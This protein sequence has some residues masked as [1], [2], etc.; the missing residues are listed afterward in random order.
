MSLQKLVSWY[1]EHDTSSFSSSSSSDSDQNLKPKITKKTKQKEFDPFSSSSSSEDENT[2]KQQKK[3]KSNET[4]PL[5][6]TKQEQKHDQNQKTKNT[7]KTKKKQRIGIAG[8][9]YSDSK[10]STKNVRNQIRVTKQTNKKTKQFAS[11]F[12]KQETQKQTK[13][14][15]K[16]IT[17]T[18]KINSGSR[19]ELLQQ[20]R[21]QEEEEKLKRMKIERVSSIEP[22][23]S[24]I[25][26]RNFERESSNEG[27]S[28]VNEKKNNQNYS[29]RRI[30][31]GW[32]RTQKTTKKSKETKTTRPKNDNTQNRLSQK[33]LED[34][35]KIFA[36]SKKRNKKGEWDNEDEDEDDDVWLD[37]KQKFDQY[38]RNKDSN[39]IAHQQKKDFF[40][41][42]QKKIPTKKAY[43]KRN[44]GNTQPEKKLNKSQQ[45]QIQLLKKKQKNISSWS[46][47]DDDDDEYNYQQTKPNE[48]I[49]GN[50]N[51]QIED[52]NDFVEPEGDPIYYLITKDQTRLSEK[53]NSVLPLKKGEKVQFL[54]LTEKDIFFKGRDENK[55]IGLVHQNYC[56]KL[57][58]GENVS[59]AKKERKEDPKNLK[60]GTETHTSTDVETKEKIIYIVKT[61]YVPDEGS[62]HVLALEKGDQIEYLGETATEGWMNGKDQ[63]GKIG[64]FYISYV[65]LQGQE[66]SSETSTESKS[67]SESGSMSKSNSESGS[68]SGSSS[69]SDTKSESEGVSQSSS[70]ASSPMKIDAK[71]EDKEKKTIY[72]ITSDYT[73]PSTLKTVLK[74]QKGEEIEFIG[75]SKK[76]GWIRGKNKEGKIGFVNQ[77]IL[78]KKLNL[79][80]ESKTKIK[81]KTKPKQNSQQE[82]KQEQK[83]NPRTKKPQKSIF[84]VTKMFMN[85]Q[86]IVNALILMKGDRIEFL[87]IHGNEGWMNG[88]DKSGNIGY[89]HKNYVKLDSGIDPFKTKNP[90]KIAPIISPQEKKIHKNGINGIELDPKKK[91]VK[92]IK[93]QK[94]PEKRKNVLVFKKGTIVE[95]IDKT[96]E[97]WWKG[98][99]SHKIGYFLSENVEELKSQQEMEKKKPKEKEKE[100]TREKT[101]TRTMKKKEKEKDTKSKVY[102]KAIKQF[103]DNPGFGTPL[104]FEKGDVIELIEKLPTGWWKGKLND[105]IGLFPSKCVTK[106][107]TE[108]N[109]N[110]QSTEGKNQTGIKSRKKKIDLSSLTSGNSGIENEKKTTSTTSNF[111]SNNDDKKKVDKIPPKPKPRTKSIQKSQQE[112]E[113]EQEQEQKQKQEQKQE[114]KPKIKPRTKQRTKRVLSN[115]ADDNTK[116]QGVWFYAIKSFENIQGLKNINSYS[117]GDQVKLIEPSKGEWFKG[118]NKKGEIGYYSINN[119][120]VV[121]EDQKVKKT[122]SLVSHGN[123]SIIVE[124]DFNI[125]DF[126]SQPKKKKKKSFFTKRKKKESK[127]KIKKREKEQERER[128]KEQERE[129]ERERE[130]EK[131]RERAKEKEEKKKIYV[132]KTKFN[133][134]NNVNNAV[135]FKKGEKVEFIQSLSNKKGWFVGKDSKNK[136]GFFKLEY[137]EEE[138]QLSTNL[139]ESKPKPKPKTQPQIKEKP[140]TTIKGKNGNKT[141]YYIS[142]CSFS[143]PKNIKKLLAYKKGEK[144]KLIKLTTGDWFSGEN[145]KGKKGYLLK[146]NFIE[147]NEN[148]QE[149]ETEIKKETEKEKEKEKETKP[150]K[151]K[152]KPRTK[153]RTNPKPK[154]KPR[155]KPR[156]IKL[157]AK[158]TTTTRTTKEKEKITK[159]KVYVKAIKK[160][161][162]NPGFGTPLHFKKGDVIELIDELPTGWWKGKLNNKS[163]LFPSKCVTKKVSINE[164]KKSMSKEKSS[165]KSS[166]SPSTVKTTTQHLIAIKALKDTKGLKNALTFRK[167]D[168]FELIKKMGDRWYLVRKS[169]KKGYVP[170]SYMK[171]KKD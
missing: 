13:K 64:Y 11:K 168:T 170:V 171:V 101:K 162:D 75:E 90:K 44:I 111:K 150:P 84:I 21:K 156:T 87:N 109:S 80:S 46:D 5:K 39:P 154:T 126:K 34:Q 28:Q 30:S 93:N 119:F 118:Q 94:N 161:K 83:Q 159:T 121:G 139:I 7:Q 66:D 112:Q 6:N 99:Y 36:K 33:Q 85:N 65:K 53:I 104:H 27:K 157:T 73:P 167:G 14:P 108:I 115:T 144:I 50:G 131:E 155:T 69:S 169:G 147:G 41:S 15:L 71:K 138:S 25:E 79:K 105:E 55:N 120:R 133:N 76:Q 132:A 107:D 70:L 24:R 77:K 22:V 20:K 12:E 97:R 35:K 151:P 68:G 123:G 110:N 106:M 18:S 152:T 56:R 78:K 102:V 153:P 43:P 137:F 19:W 128:E 91:Y 45:Q 51:K 129:R 100:K 29:Q 42:Q 95:L 67:S 3:K 47:E 57:K 26:R 86:G 117:K 88:K 160:F 163:G 142:K 103:K 116:T 166:K 140:S 145:K 98:N 23:G 31:S 135:K 96:N 143:N 125:D 158:T 48:N 74:V 40:E 17:Q 49:N 127:G 38:S 114:Q 164:I 60:T 124:S 72:I 1:N 59:K 136:T 148:I 62:T 113:Q 2:P 16:K 165:P 134:P 146:K 8:L 52:M 58:E 149:T 122:Y 32:G 92:A 61:K 54:C 10:S 63:N 37:D 130:R 141:I 4:Q 82:Q 81:T 9:K 89:F